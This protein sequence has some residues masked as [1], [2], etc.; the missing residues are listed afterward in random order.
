MFIR[1]QFSLAVHQKLF[2]GWLVECI[3][4]EKR[5]Y[6]IIHADHGQKERVYTY[7]NFVVFE[8]KFMIQVS[9][10]LPTLVSIF[11]SLVRFR[12]AELDT[13]SVTL[14]WQKSVNETS[15][16]FTCSFAKEKNLYVK[17]EKKM[18]DV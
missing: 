1:L 14:S 6:F 18:Q 3:L 7:K 17:E 15:V 11:T 13:A 16:T 12:I 8:V 5:M 4:C 10:T 9:S 2:I